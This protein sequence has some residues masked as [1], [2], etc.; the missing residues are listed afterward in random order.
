MNSKMVFDRP[1]SVS[2]AAYTLADKA[3]ENTQSYGNRPY[4][5]GLLIAGVDDTSAHLYEFQPS[6]LVTEYNA[7]AIGARS[8]AARTYLERNY[9]T[10]DTTEDQEVIKFALLALRE[11][12]AQD[13][14]LTQQNT[15]VAI[16]SKGSKLRLYED[17]QVQQFLD[18]LDSTANSRSR[19]NDDDNDDEKETGD[20]VKTEEP[21]AV[22]EPEP[23]V[24]GETGAAEGVA[25][26]DRMDTD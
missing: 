12:L 19:G 25:S 3:Q 15:S 9:E 13:K 17:E 16:V 7:S 4:G 6:G 14:E 21:E 1:I 2:K 10:L 8:Q 23:T 11:T 24:E 5:V 26:E 22:T 20:D 18:L